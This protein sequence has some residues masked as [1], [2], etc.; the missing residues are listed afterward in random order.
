MVGSITLGCDL[1]LLQTGTYGEVILGG[2][3]VSLTLFGF[4]VQWCYTA[5]GVEI[6]ARTGRTQVSVTATAEAVTMRLRDARAWRVVICV[7]Y[8]N[9]VGRD[10]KLTRIN[11]KKTL[12]SG[13]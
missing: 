2:C 8:N 6:D 3:I 10:V 7:K 11:L 5:D 12:N 13:L 1:K 4:F 9:A